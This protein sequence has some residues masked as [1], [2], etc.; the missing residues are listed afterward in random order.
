MNPSSPS[1]SFSS[2][3]SAQSLYN[4]GPQAPGY[5]SPWSS[6]DQYLPQAATGQEMMNQGLAMEQMLPAELRAT[7]ANP[8]LNLSADQLKRYED[9]FTQQ[10]INP[11]VAKEQAKLASS[12]RGTSTFAGAQLGQMKAQGALS[13]LQAGLDISNQRAQLALAKRG[14]FFGGE[15]AMAQ[16]AESNKLQ[17]GTTAAN[18][19]LQES[20][21][22]NQ[23][24]LGV[25]NQ[26][27]QNWWNANSTAQAEARMNSDNSLGWAKLNSD[28]Y[29]KNQDLNMQAAD[30]NQAYNKSLWSAGAAAGGGLARGAG[31]VA[32]KMFP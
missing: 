8:D 15:G 10:Y 29:W 24:G 30:R 19:T 13:A 14:S 9:A 31:A 27:S 28:N 17:R 12:G 21:N 11:A 26:Q 20:Q 2:S 4:Q 18:L 3:S 6:V 16:Q 22:R 7:N 1:P 25:Y 5:S 32:S 23:F